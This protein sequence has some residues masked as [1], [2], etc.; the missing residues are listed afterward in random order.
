MEHE[1]IVFNEDC[2]VGMARYPD[3]HFDLAV[4]DPPYFSGPERRAYYGRSVSATNI[5]RRNYPVT[6]H[7]QVPGT[8]Y[9]RELERVSKRY[10]VGGCNYYDYRFPPGGSFGISATAHPRSLTARSPPPTSTIVSGCTAICG[11][12]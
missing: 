2:M 12:A 5:K 3:K 10:I 4:V 11:T 9:F 6:E 8:D 7:W 1:N